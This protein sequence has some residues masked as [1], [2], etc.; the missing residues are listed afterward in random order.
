MALCFERSGFAFLQ[1]NSTNRPPSPPPPP[2]PPSCFVSSSLRSPVLL[3]DSTVLT[4]LVSL[5]TRFSPP[6]ARDWVRFSRAK[7]LFCEELVRTR[8]NESRRPV[9]EDR[10][11]FLSLIVVE[12]DEQ[13][14]AA[15]GTILP[16]RPSFCSPMA[17]TV[18][19]T[20]ELLL[21]ARTS[22]SGAGGPFSASSA[23]ASALASAILPITIPSTGSSLN[24]GDGVQVLVVIN[25]A[26]SGGAWPCLCVG[27]APRRSP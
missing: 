2:A 18:P 3:R 25:V 6:L 20:T 22:A 12:E 5:S 27:S 7:R 21:P 23:S 17:T 19:F 1:S 8:A 13:V 10:S 26:D 15:R 9:D 4:K 14:E 11:L 24:M 16:S